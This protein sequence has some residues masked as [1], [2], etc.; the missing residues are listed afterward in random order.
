MKRHFF[1]SL[2]DEALGGACFEP[3]IPLIRG[4]DTKVKEELYQK[5]TTGQKALFMFYAYFNHAKNSIEE[6]YWWGAYYYAQPRAWKAIKNGLEY[7]G[8]NEMM[9]LFVKLE[10]L[11]EAGNFSRSIEDFNV[12]YND[13]EKDPELMESIALLNIDF[14][15]ISP[16]TLKDIGEKIRSNPSEYIQIV[17]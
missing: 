14:T 3:Y 13:I 8:A 9:C 5:L 15:E 1:D 16:K 12:S 7:F 6:F 4:R 2:E 11:F 10:Q 17:D